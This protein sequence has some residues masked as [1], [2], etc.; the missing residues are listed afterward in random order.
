MV[1]RKEQEEV[2][3]RLK[4]DLNDGVKSDYTMSITD[5]VLSWRGSHI[6][7]THTQ[8]PTPQLKQH[9]VSDTT[10]LRNIIS[11]FYSNTVSRGVRV[12]IPMIAI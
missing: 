10:A 6:F 8:H 11:R 7:S 5:S 2:A 1:D 12:P 4:S 3:N 9:I